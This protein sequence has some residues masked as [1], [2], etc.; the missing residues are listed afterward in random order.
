MA[1]FSVGSHL[2]VSLINSQSINYTEGVGVGMARD[3]ANLMVGQYFKKR[4]DLVEIF[5]VSGSGAGIATMSVFVRWVTRE[6]GWRLGLQVGGHM[7][8]Q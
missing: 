2:T 5:L 1:L 4:R 8:P 7:C 3:T 6:I